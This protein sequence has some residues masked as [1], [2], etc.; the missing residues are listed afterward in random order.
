MYQELRGMRPSKYLASV[1]NSELDGKSMTH[2][3]TS[4][5]EKYGFGIIDGAAVATEMFGGGFVNETGGP[6]PPQEGH[7]VEIESPRKYSWLVE[8]E[9]YN[10]RGHIN[11]HGEDNGTIEQIAAKIEMEYRESKDKPIQRMSIMN[12]SNPHWPTDRLRSP[13]LPDDYGRSRLQE[14]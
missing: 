8:G 9:T 11:E 1:L 7:W 13:D 5:N 12:W 10:L 6:V 4:W 14:W 2:F 3:R